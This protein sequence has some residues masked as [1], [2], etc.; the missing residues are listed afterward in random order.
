MPLLAR[1]KPLQ[2]LLPRF[3]R[4]RK[5][6]LLHLQKPLCDQPQQA[7]RAVRVRHHKHRKLG[8][9]N[10]NEPVHPRGRLLLRK[11]VGQRRL[12]RRLLV[13]VHRLHKLLLAPV[14]ARQFTPVAQ[15]LCKQGAPLG[16]RLPLPR[17]PLRLL[18]PLVVGNLRRHA[19]AGLSCPL[20]FLKKLT[21]VL[22][23]LTHAYR[24]TFTLT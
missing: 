9:T 12:L 7:K 4:L 15:H 17:F 20:H 11:N 2:Q 1:L 13:A 18:L 23:T 3:L 10:L 14:P 21:K 19:G 6:P 24:Q 22:R 5:Q 8:Q 16:L